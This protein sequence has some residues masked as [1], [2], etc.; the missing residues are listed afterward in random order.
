MTNI[1]DLRNSIQN[2]DNQLL[3][4]MKQRNEI[5]KQVAFYKSQNDIELINEEVYESKLN[6][7]TNFAKSNGLEVEFIAQLWEL[8][9]EN[10]VL[11]QTIHYQ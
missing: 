10:S 2:L 11:T 4:I 9:H 1:V 3:N 8:I 5:V 6:I 7:F